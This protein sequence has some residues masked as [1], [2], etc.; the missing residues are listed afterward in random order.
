MSDKRKDKRWKR[1]HGKQRK[2]PDMDHVRVVYRCKDEAEAKRRV[3][4]ADALVGTPF[5]S[6]PGIV[7]HKATLFVSKNGTPVPAEAVGMV[8]NDALLMDVIS[9]WG[10]DG[11]LTKDTYDDD[12]HREI[13]EYAQKAYEGVEIPQALRKPK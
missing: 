12:L 1:E 4:R 5:V 6:L 7:D 10:Q 11:P 3:D 8:F 13:Y 2:G 9:G